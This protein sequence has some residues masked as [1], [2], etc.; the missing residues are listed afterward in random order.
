[1]SGMQH[2]MHDM[3][4][5]VDAYRPRSLQTYENIAATPGK[6]VHQTPLYQRRNMN[7]RPKSF[8]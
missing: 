7:R 2:L 1:M 5:A 6:V 3:Q 4:R 8:C